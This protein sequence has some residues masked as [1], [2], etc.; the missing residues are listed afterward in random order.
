MFS[1]ASVLTSQLRGAHLPEYISLTG[2]TVDEYIV[3]MHG[4]S[5]ADG[6][7]S[8]ATNHS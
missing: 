1:L 4:G 2:S 5:W 6:D 3:A 7:I 8:S